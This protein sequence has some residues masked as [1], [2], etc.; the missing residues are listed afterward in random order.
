MLA[1]RLVRVSRSV[2]YLALGD[3]ARR[4]W[5]PR[6]LTC[7]VVSGGVGSG[8][9]VF[10]HPPRAADTTVPVAAARRPPQPRARVISRRACAMGAGV[11]RADIRCCAMMRPG[12]SAVPCTVPRMLSVDLCGARIPSLGARAGLRGGAASSTVGG[13]RAVA[14]GEA[15]RGHHFGRAHAHPHTPSAHDAHWARSGA[16][17]AAAAAAT[18]STMK[19]TLNRPKIQLP[20]DGAAAA[21]FQVYASAALRA[22]MRPADE[23][24]ALLER[25]A[26][27]A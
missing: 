3:R 14:S 19:R 1:C 11:G 7:A 26:K 5:L 6:R 21:A 17:V 24:A 20:A 13:A 27:A 22:A 15:Q 9:V 10:R 25:T 23:C 4:S 12:P 8:A 18:S 2:A 16:G